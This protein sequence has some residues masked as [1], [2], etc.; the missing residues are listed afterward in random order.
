MRDKHQQVGGRPAVD[1]PPFERAVGGAE[2][3]S[4]GRDFYGYNFGDYRDFEGSDPDADDYGDRGPDWDD[5][6]TGWRPGEPGGYEGSDIRGY[7]GREY[8]NYGGGYEGYYGEE[9]RG[10]TDYES[11]R[12]TT[13]EGREPVGEWSSRHAHDF[14][15][16][17]FRVPR[18]RGRAR[19]AKARDRRRLG[20][21]GGRHFGPGLHHGPRR[22]G[23]RGVAPKGYSRSDSSI[24]EE[25]CALLEDDPD[26]DPSDVTVSVE[27]REVVL[28]GTVDDRWAKRYI[29]DLAYS[30]RGVSDVVNRLSVEPREAPEALEPR[31][32]VVGPRR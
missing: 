4:E 16:P 30:V 3:L 12:W 14:E 10:P 27:E 11:W 23:L 25:L 32:R 29:E 2:D 24:Y 21:P 20:A 26:V 17:S 22:R 6:E 7:E 15:H 18:T 19:R 13:L 9:A 28:S 5:E 31:V 8:P 1:E